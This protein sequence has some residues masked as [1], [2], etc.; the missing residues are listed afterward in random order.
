MKLLTL[1][2][3]QPIKTHKSTSS[4]PSHIQQQFQLSSRTKENDTVLSFATQG[5]AIAKFRQAINRGFST[6]GLN[7]Q[8]FWGKFSK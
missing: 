3:F 1:S 5:R 7:N 8:K 2:D 4:V 6:S